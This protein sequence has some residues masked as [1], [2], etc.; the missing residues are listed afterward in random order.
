VVAPLLVFL[1]ISLPI[2][3][4]F[5]HESKKYSPLFFVEVIAELVFLVDIVLNFRTG[6]FID[7]VGEEAITRLSVEYHPLYVAR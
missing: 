5:N 1:T 2:N 4:C 6:Y 7:G 3:F